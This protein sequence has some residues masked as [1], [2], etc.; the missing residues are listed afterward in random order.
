M[1]L[2]GFRAYLVAIFMVS[3]IHGLVVFFGGNCLGCFLGFLLLLF[4][5]FLGLL[6]LGVYFFGGGGSPL[7]GMAPRTLAELMWIGPQ[8]Y[9]EVHSSNALVL[10]FV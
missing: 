10:S 6:F 5:M 7:K 3:L 8:I 2:F 9:R 1:A 4:D